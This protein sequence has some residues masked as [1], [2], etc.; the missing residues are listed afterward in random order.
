MRI[1]FVR[2]G[3]PDYKKDCLTELGHKQAE[4]AAERLKDEVISEIH[5]S[6]CGRVYETA[7]HIAA[8]HGLPVEKHDFMRELHWGTP[9]L[10]DDDICDLPGV[11]IAD[12]KIIQR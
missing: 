8:L 10:P 1:I 9:D 5:A 6:S 3:H 4:A 11:F 2:H 7:K 12:I